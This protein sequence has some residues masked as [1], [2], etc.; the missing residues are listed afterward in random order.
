MYPFQFVA[1]HGVGSFGAAWHHYFS[2]RDA[3][4]EN[5]QLRKQLTEMQQRVNEAEDKTKFAEQLD[6]YV[7]WRSNQSFPA[8]DARVIARDAN[9]WFNTVVIDQGSLA[10]V[11][12]RH[13]GDDA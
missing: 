13:A 6:T 10:G 11:Q 7:K 2:L 3:R 1:A 5:E 12:K 8:I 9:Q 4:V